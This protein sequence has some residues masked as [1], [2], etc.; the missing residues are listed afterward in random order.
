MDKIAG[1]EV[2]KHNHRNSCWI[3]LYGKVYDVTGTHSGY[4]FDCEAERKLHFLDEHPGG[5]HIILRCAG[6]DATAE[7]ESVYSPDLIEETLS[8]TACRGLVDPK[9]IPRPQSTATAQQQR[10]PKSG[11]PPLSSMISVDDF[12]A[13]AKQYPTPTGWA[14]Y[15]SGAD[16]EYNKH[17]AA[18]AFRK[19]KLRPRILRKVDSVD[20]RTTILGRHTSMPV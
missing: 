2:T 19:L 4:S 3:A 20:T 18:R 6:Q 10:K 8:P 13:V 1:S 9:S 14:Y 17:H 5:A 12:E 7:Y 11:F 16:D 15:S